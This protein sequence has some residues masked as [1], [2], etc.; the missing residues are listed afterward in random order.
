[1][2]YVF[3]KILYMEKSQMYRPFTHM[4]KGLGREVL[5]LKLFWLTKDMSGGQSVSNE[6][7]EERN[8]H[9][10]AGKLSNL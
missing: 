9:S 1:M 4:S 6:N 7:W 2:S 5:S 10:L 3:I 8:I